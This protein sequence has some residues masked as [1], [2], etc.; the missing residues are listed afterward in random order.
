MRDV[1]CWVGCDEIS[2][3]IQKLSVDEYWNLP[4][5][6]DV[7][8]HI[9]LVNIT[10]DMPEDASRRWKMPTVIDKYVHLCQLIYKIGEDVHLC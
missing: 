6:S 10:V 3:K 2:L 7:C 8:W 1:T 4:E 5:A 9:L